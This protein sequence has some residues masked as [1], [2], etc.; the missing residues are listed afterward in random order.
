MIRDE[1]LAALN[2]LIEQCKDEADL[3]QEA[4]GLTEEPA[5]GELFTKTGRERERL[6]SELSTY[7]RQLG[8]LPAAPD[9]D[10]ETLEEL[11]TRLKAALS[12]DK[13]LVLIDERLQAEKELSSLIESALREKMPVQVHSFLVTMQQNVTDT[14]DEL[15]AARRRTEAGSENEG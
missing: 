15:A 1:R 13:R 6:A 5:L 14:M 12:V 9:R 8:D 2:N 4:A 10:R 7:L 3:Y 11:V